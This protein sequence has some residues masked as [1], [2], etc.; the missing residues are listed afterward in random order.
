MRICLHQFIRPPKGVAVAGVG[1]CS[2][3]QAHIDNQRCLRFY[4]I[5]VKTMKVKEVKPCAVKPAPM[6]ST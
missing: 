4:P 3:C 1:D 5:T 2:T 6:S